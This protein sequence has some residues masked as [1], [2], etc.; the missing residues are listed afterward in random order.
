MARS[1]P[2]RT[3]TSDG[4]WERVGG[5]DLNV[6]GQGM[7]SA[8]LIFAAGIVAEWK[9]PSVRRLFVESGRAD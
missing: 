7:F 2:N 3:G 6:A 8:I 5:P 9:D 4:G 1:S